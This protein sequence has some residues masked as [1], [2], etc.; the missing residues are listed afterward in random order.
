MRLVGRL[1][2]VLGMGLVLLGLV[3]LVL[4]GMGLVGRLLVVLG[5]GLVLL[6][7]VLLVSTVAGVVGVARLVVM[8]IVFLSIHGA[9]VEAN[10]TAARNGGAFFVEGD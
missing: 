6:G 10:H 5:M 2:V 7:L 9:T 3:L 4:L 1:L 8:R